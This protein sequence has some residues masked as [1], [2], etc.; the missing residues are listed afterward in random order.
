MTLL[1]NYTLAHV[2]LLK[3]Y[4]IPAGMYASQIWATPGPFLRQG[5]EKDNP[6]QKWLLT[7]L[8][9]IRPVPVEEARFYVGTSLRLRPLALGRFC[10]TMHTIQGIKT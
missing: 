1:T 2:W 9:R 7:V 10:F 6:I 8:K 4:A 3:T 5:R